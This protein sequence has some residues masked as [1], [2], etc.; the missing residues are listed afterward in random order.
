[1]IIAGF[2]II[3]LIVDDAVTPNPKFNTEYSE[4]YNENLF[5]NK[6]LGISEKH[7]IEL[8]GEPTKREN[9]EIS[10]HYL[11]TNDTSNVHF[12][13]GST[14]VSLNGGTENLKYK[15]ITFDKNGILTDIITE[16]VEFKKEKFIGLKNKEIIQKFG[17]PNKKMICNCDF[18]ILSFSKLKDG[19]Y[20]GK[21]P[22]INLR[23]V[24]INN[25]KKVDKIISKIGNPDNK[26]DGS[27]KMN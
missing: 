5:N 22:I 8:F 21:T 11:Y 2:I 15:L 27:C 18:E 6:L 4:K 3:S 13:E 16:K 25:Q 12:I 20:K 9:L 19:P 1:M 26:Y 14:G 23:K 10:E 24:I 17:E 7:L